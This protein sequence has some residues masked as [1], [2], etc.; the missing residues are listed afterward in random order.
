MNE[1]K[2]IAL[3]YYICESYDTEL[4]WYCQRMSNNAAPAFS[5]QELLTIYLYSVMEE[6]KYSVKSIWN[7][8]KRYML[9]WFP[10]LPS[11]QGFNER[12]NRLA[13]VFAPLVACLLRD[14]DQ[15]GIDRQVSLLDSMPIMTCSGRRAGKVAPELTAKGYCSTKKQHY[16]GLKLHSIA[17]RRAHQMPFPEYLLITPASAHDLST[18]RP[19]LPRLKNRAL[20][21]DKIYAHNVLQKDLF[22]TINTQLYTPI[23][24]VN[25]DNDYLRQF[26]HAADKLFSRAVS[27]IRQPM[28]AFFNW[29]I[30][31][32]NLQDASKV[33]SQRGLIVHVFGK[34]A[35][36]I[37]LWVF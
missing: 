10:D 21:G 30:Q 18:V 14:C 8:A 22:Q 3:Y 13:P 35:A 32:T 6:E 5:D 2:I 37:A 1:L 33:R 28:E 19:I 11:Y 20:F 36:A 17:F 9:S 27:Q 23:R 34:L 15:Q 26:K 16:Y 29:I 4:V 31:K 24:L 7:Y 25:G 12:L